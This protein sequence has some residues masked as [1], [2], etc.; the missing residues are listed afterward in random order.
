MNSKEN[1]QEVVVVDLFAG[2]GGLGEGLKQAGLHIA[3]AIE[4]DERAAETYRANHPET[5]VWCTDIKLITGKMI[6]DQIGHS[7]KIILAGGSPCQ[8]WSTFKTETGGKQGLEDSRGKLIYEYLRVVRELK[9]EIIVFENVS[10][11]VGAKHLPAFNTFKKLLHEQ[12]GL[13]LEHKVLNA[14]DYGVAQNR[15]R[16]IMIGR[17]DWQP[18]P[19]SFLEPISGPKTLREQL[20]GIEPSAYAAFDAQDGIIMNKIAPGKCWNVLDI[21]TA[22]FALSKDYRGTCNNCRKEYKPQYDNVCPNC[23]VRDFRNTLGVITS[24]YRRLS[25]DKPSPT[26]CTVLTTKKHGT[27]T[28]PEETRGLSI[29][30]CARI[31][32]FPDDYVFIGDMKDQYRQI[33]NAVPVSLGRAIGYCLIKTL[34][35]SGSENEGVDWLQ[36]IAKFKKHRNRKAL[37]TLERDLLNSLFSYLKSNRP[38]PHKYE[39]YITETWRRISDLTV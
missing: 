19:F 2:A 29:R 16:V 35:K 38:I 37:T 32:G 34:S 4:I 17:Q 11:M 25:W 30:E 12:T 28:H 5:T 10:Y 15:E 36:W 6:R 27:L 31:Q 26:I 22:M 39:I 14:L 24:Y 20:K 9:P 33:G 21:D 7:V 1:V 3:L 8:S 23:G 18:N 13:K